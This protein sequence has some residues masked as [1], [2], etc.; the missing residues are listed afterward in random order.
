MLRAAEDDLQKWGRHFVLGY[1]DERDLEILIQKGA[2]AGVYITQRN[3]KNKTF[4]DVQTLLGRWQSQQK[5]GQRPPL[6]IAADQEG[7]EVSRLSPPLTP[8]PALSTLAAA[9]EAK[10]FAKIVAYAQTHAQEL[11]A[12]G[13]TMNLAPVVDL[14]DAS[15]VT[16][17][18]WHSRI[19]DRAISPNPETVAGVASIYCQ[20]LAR[21][22][23][24]ATLK[25]FPG[26]GSVRGDTHLRNILASRQKEDFENQDWLPYRKVFSECEPAVMLSHVMATELDPDRPVSLSRKVVQDVL[27]GDLQ[28]Q[29]LLITDDFGMSPISDRSGGVG[30]A[31]CEALA[32]G[33]DLILISFDP[34]LYYEAM[35]A[36]L[37]AKP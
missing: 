29:G 16:L 36:L 9:Y 2:V 6:L 13:V 33:V 20:E 11:Q 7:G 21:F 19:Y 27:R 30:V 10:D 35:Y 14:Q 8:L 17:L 31:A 22:G 15:S 4:A 23:I 26:L 28:F 3:L 18:D 34:D 1:T 5:E 12:L 24:R 25:H 32:A 37:T